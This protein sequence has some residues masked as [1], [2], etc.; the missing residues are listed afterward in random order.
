MSRAL[1]ATQ[2]RHPAHRTSGH[3]LVFR[4]FLGLVFVLAL[5]SAVALYFKQEEQFARIEAR[6][7]ELIEQ[8]ALADRAYQD[9]LALQKQ[10]DTDTYIEQVAREALGMVK[11]DEIIFE[12]P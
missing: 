11:P 3:Q 8:Q 9:R 10:L 5:A 12:D 2:H 6:Q 1:T 7:A 4:I